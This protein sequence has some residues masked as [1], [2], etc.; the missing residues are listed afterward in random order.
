M[1]Q[2][3]TKNTTPTSAPE[4]ADNL[5]AEPGLSDALGLGDELGF[6]VAL[7]PLGATV[8]TTSIMNGSSDD[9][10]AVATC[11]LE[12]RPEQMA[13]PPLRSHSKSTSMSK[14][15]AEAEKV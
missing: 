12:S 2:C 11:E 3:A 6:P 8:D 7:A 1:S 13:C 4:D 15:S 10:V 9:S 5:G 14:P